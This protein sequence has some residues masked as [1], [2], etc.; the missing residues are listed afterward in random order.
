MKG[1]N[2]MREFI[3]KCADLCNSGYNK[4][5]AYVV[6]GASALGAALGLQS[7]DS[8]AAV[9][10]G[11]EA[12]FTEAATDF[13]TVVG[14]GWTLFLVIMGGMVLFKIVKKVFFRS[15]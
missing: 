15:T 2:N 10:L 5:K 13:G 14:Y 8:Q 1:V 4:A 12:V 11:V 3:R 7:S 9:P 6:T